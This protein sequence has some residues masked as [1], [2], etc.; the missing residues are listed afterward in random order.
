[1]ISPISVLI[2]LTVLASVFL[3]SAITLITWLLSKKYPYTWNVNKRIV[4]VFLVFTI[5]V[6]IGIAAKR[7]VDKFPSSIFQKHFGFYP[8]SSVRNLHAEIK[9][10]NELYSE[11]LTFETNETVI[12]EILDTGYNEVSCGERYGN[13]GYGDD[14]LTEISSSSQKRCYERKFDIENNTIIYDW[15]SG[16]TYFEHYFVR[17]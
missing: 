10:T 1:M 5:P 12:H 4:V 14:L 17:F 7:M 9:Q 2:F 3:L 6:G 11:S 13:F 8:T 15:R 16:K